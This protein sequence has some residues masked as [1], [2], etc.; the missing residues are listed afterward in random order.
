MPISI[1]I[2]NRKSHIR[3]IAPPGNDAANRLLTFA[4]NILTG[5]KFSEYPA[6][7]RG[8]II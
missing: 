6:G 3:F 2:A 5:A 4:E 8:L 7:Y 1:P